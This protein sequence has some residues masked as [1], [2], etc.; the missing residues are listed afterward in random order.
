MNNFERGYYTGIVET[1][2]DVLQIDKEFEWLDD[3]WNEENKELE[4]T[5]DYIKD[6]LIYKDESEFDLIEDY[7]KYADKIGDIIYK[8]GEETVEQINKFCDLYNICIRCSRIEIG[9]DYFV[10]YL[11][12][13]RLYDIIKWD[14]KIKSD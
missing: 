13:K 5:L 6:D 8:K 14:K 3:E 11:Y 4:I 12:F 9:H 1:I 7:K 10:I 2:Y